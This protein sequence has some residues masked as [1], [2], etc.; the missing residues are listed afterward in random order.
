MEPAASSADI[1]LD[2]DSDTARKKAAAEALREQEKFMTIGTGEAECKGCGYTY[3]PKIG[4][5][6]YPISPGMK[7]ENVPA[8]WQ[9]PVCGAEKTLFESKQ[10][11]VAGFAANQG[12][13]LGTNTMTGEQKSLLIYGALLLFFVLF[14][15]GYTLE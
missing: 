12:Y 15:L 10:K 2:Q 4:D 3:N 11:E 9:C 6:D 8:D 1:E 13:G 5:P 14:L 7:F